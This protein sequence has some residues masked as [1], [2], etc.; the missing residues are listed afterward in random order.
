MNLMLLDYTL[1]V[2][3]LFVILLMSEQGCRNNLTIK[4]QVDNPSYSTDNNPPTIL[5]TKGG[6]DS[7][8]NSITSG[9]ISDPG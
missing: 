2:I 7:S 3:F 5:I 1:T 9:I 6:A 4:Q 8:D